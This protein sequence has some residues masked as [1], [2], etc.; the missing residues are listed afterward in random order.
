MKDERG[1]DECL[2]GAEEEHGR[3]HD[4]A[5]EAV[6]HAFAGQNPWHNPENF[7]MLRRL[8]VIYSVAAI[9]ILLI[10]MFLAGRRRQSA[11]VRDKIKRLLKI[12]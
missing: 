9:F 3:D 2:I 6:S 1:T 7:K 5:D 8:A 12:K 4:A 10:N 11:F